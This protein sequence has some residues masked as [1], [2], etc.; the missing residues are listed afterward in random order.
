VQAAWCATRVKDTYLRA[1][2]LRLKSRRGPKKAVVAVAASM[3]T[4]AYFML[5]DGVDYRDLGPDHFDHIDKAK[6]AERLVRKLQAL[7]YGVE[8][9]AA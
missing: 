9:T 6:A 5:R 8:L 1:L 4:A 7:G 2:F 3:L